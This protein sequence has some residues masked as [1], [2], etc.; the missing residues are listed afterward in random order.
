MER[1]NKLLLKITILTL[2]FSSFKQITTKKAT[3]IET[4]FYIE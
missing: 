2:N 3:P 1:K 4:A